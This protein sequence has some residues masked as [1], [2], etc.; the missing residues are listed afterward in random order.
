MTQLKKS[1]KMLE[2]EARYGKEVDKVLKELF[3]TEYTHH[4]VGKVLSISQDTLRKWILKLGLTVRRVV[5]RPDEYFVIKK[6]AEEHYD[7]P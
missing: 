7:A 5:L 2:I 6:R 4:A 1:D 3:F